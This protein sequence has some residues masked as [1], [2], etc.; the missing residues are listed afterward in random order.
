MN[1]NPKNYANADIEP[2]HDKTACAPS[3]DCLISL[4]CPHDELG[5]L[6]TH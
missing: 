1:F 3:E 2:H 4:H 6:V 5:P